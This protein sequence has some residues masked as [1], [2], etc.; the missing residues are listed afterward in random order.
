MKKLNV[1]AK[2]VALLMFISLFSIA[3]YS[4]FYINVGGGYN[5]GIATQS[6]LF[7]YEGTNDIEKTE[8]VKVSLGKGLNF[9][10]NLGYM[11]NGNIGIDLQ[12]SYLLGDETSGE[13]KDNFTY[14]NINY[15][16]YEKESIKSQMFRVNPSIII[17]S[18][19]DKLDPYAKFGVILGFGSITYNRL[20]EEYENNQIQDKEVEKWKMDGGMAFGISSALGLMYHIS[21]LISVYGELNLVGMSYAPKKGVMTEY[22]INGADQLP[23]LT[24]D[25][26]E[27]DFVDDI[28]YD[29]DNPPSSAEPSKEL[30][31]Y[32]PYSSIGL[33]IGVRFSF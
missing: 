29:Y 12:C 13:S 10:L 32:F 9:G 15:Y 4:Q 1:V 6:L 31:F 20:Y 16:D 22:T 24:T 33:N 27:I 26:K 5:L 14:F 28:T 19:F 7:N 3:A 25:D 17:A 11:F 18:G 8:N 23:E 2:K 30:K 21:D